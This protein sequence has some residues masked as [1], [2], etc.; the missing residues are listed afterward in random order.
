MERREGEFLSAVTNR[1][2]AAAVRACGG[3]VERAWVVLCEEAATR[4][5]KGLPTSRA[6]VEFEVEEREDGVGGRRR[7]E[8][9][10][11]EWVS[12]RQLLPRAER[13]CEEPGLIR[14]M[15]TLLLRC[16]R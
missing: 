4:G 15:P 2:L 3:D 7:A 11:D 9:M 1:E 13:L 16:A 5:A 12:A 10:V 14:Y 8:A 6:H